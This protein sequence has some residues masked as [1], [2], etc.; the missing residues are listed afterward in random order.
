[1]NDDCGPILVLFMGK[2][3]LKLYFI[4]YLVKLEHD[5]S[6]ILYGKI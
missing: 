4:K 6:R 5:F 1:M 2:L 3:K